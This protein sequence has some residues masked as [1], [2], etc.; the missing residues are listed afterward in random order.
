MNSDQTFLGVN[1]FV[2]KPCQNKVFQPRKAKASLASETASNPIPVVESLAYANDDV[3]TQVH[4]LME[5]MA[6]SYHHED[7][8]VHGDSQSPIALVPFL[9]S[10]ILL[11][12]LAQS[13]ELYVWYPF[14]FPTQ[15]TNS[16]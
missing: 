7:V 16:I 5:E 1:M 14:D 8:V 6:K 4:P 15:K 12:F 11:C 13:F 2:I 9:V 10:N 3:N